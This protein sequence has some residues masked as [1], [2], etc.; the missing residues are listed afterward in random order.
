MKSF[1]FVAAVVL[2]VIFAGE[3]VNAFEINDV[4]INGEQVVLWT[5]YGGNISLEKGQN[6][7]PLIVELSLNM[8]SASIRDFRDKKLKFLVS[9]PR[10]QD[11]RSFSS[12]LRRTSDEVGSC[13]SSER[14]S[15]FIFF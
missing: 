3:K 7:I 15:V 11:F 9:F 13:Y 12:F 1:F 2:S 8:H 6:A 14:C 4:I 5:T 10:S